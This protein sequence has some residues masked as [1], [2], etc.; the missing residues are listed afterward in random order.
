MLGM[1]EPLLMGWVSR[2]PVLGERTDLVTKNG[3][4]KA[5]A[6]VDGRAAG[7]WTLERGRPA[8]EPFARIA[9][10]DLAALEADGEDVARYLGS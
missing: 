6:L 4:F 9:A 2:E 10:A 1:F 3:I 8:L 7:T 5:F